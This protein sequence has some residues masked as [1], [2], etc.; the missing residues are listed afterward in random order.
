MKK[1]LEFLRVLLDSGQERQD[2]ERKFK[3]DLYWYEDT[4]Y[5]LRLPILLLSA[6]AVV[7]TVTFTFVKLENNRMEELR[8]ARYLSAAE[9]R[10]RYKY[11]LPAYKTSDYY[12]CGTGG[13]V[14]NAK[15]LLSIGETENSDQLQVREVPR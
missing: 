2:F 5:V 3:R 6:V 10:C 13:N 12:A 11:N 7:L 8:Q 9:T 4:V 15:V 14:A 1:V